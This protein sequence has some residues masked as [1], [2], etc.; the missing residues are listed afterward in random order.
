MEN[1]QS[2]DIIN[3][4][5]KKHAREFDEF[6]KTLSHTFPV[7]QIEKWTRLA[8]LK[9]LGVNKSIWGSVRWSKSLGKPVGVPLAAGLTFSQGTFGAKLTLIS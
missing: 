1:K 5:I 8:P 4:E 2:D 9:H 3:K 6:R 7:E